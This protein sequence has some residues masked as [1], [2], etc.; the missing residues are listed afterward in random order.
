MPGTAL[1]TCRVQEILALL[2]LT[3]CLGGPNY[4]L[5]L[6]TLLADLINFPDSTSQQRV[7]CLFVSWLLCPVDS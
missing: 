4:K 2:M 5:E 1:S 3:L 6:V 7:V